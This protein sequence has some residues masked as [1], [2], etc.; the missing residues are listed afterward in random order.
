MPVNDKTVKVMMQAIE[1]AD[2]EWRKQEPQ[3]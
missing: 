2:A 1:A 3:A